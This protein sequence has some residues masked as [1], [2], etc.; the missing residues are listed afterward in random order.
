MVRISR[1]NKNWETITRKLSLLGI[2]EGK[3][4]RGQKQEMKP[5]QQRI[6]ANQPQ[7]PDLSPQAYELQKVHIKILRP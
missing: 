5:Q 3:I 7:T 2:S 1:M 6:P 4:G